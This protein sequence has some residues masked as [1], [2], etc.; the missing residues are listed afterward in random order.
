M[1]FGT[2]CISGNISMAIYYPTTVVLRSR[3]SW[4]IPQCVAD[5]S[6]NCSR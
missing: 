6:A 5:N 3:D 1:F 2:Q 4:E